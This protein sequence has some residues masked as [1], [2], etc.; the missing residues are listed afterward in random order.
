MSFFRSWGSF[1]SKVWDRLRESLSPIADAIQFGRQVGVEISPAQAQRELSHVY[2]GIEHAQ[3]IAQLSTADYIPDDWYTD[4]EV[5]WRRPFAYN[6]EFYGR[7][8]QTGRYAHT[9]RVLTFS[10]PLTIEEIEEEARA[11]FG[12]TGKYPQLA[13]MQMGVT[14]AYVRSGEDRL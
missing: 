7:D 11:N 13:I 4:A 5:P 2:S 14:E 9:N 3:D 12:E 10:R 1:A 6:V 8:L